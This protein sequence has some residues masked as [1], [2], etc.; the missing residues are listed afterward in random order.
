MRS[1]SE[2]SVT[3][4]VSDDPPQFIKF[5]HGFEMMS[6]SDSTEDLRNTERHIYETCEK[7]V[8][9]RVRKLRRL[10]RQIGG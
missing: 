1:W 9:E 10:M 6:P 2:C 3:V 8:N 7:I 5:T 4:A